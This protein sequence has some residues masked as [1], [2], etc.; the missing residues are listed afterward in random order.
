MRFSSDYTCLRIA[1]LTEDVI[2]KLVDKYNPGNYKEDA[3]IDGTRRLNEA[4]SQELPTK[5]DLVTEWIMSLDS[6]WAFAT[7]HDIE[8]FTSVVKFFFGHNKDPL[9]KALVKE[10]ADEIETQINPKNL[11]DFSWES[12]YV[13]R[14]RYS[15]AQATEELNLL[16]KKLPESAKLFYDDGA[17]KIVAAMRPEAA[18]ALGQG[19]EW[20]TREP[21]AA[22]DYLFRNKEI[23][24]LYVVYL[25]NR[26]VAQIHID[27]FKNTV[28]LKN[29]RNQNMTANSELT[30]V[31]WNS[32]LMKKVLDTFESLGT[33]ILYRSELLEKWVRFANKDILDYMSRLP[34]VAVAY[35]MKILKGPWPEAEPAIAKD[36]ETALKY[37]ERVLHKRF[38]EAEKT[39]LSGTEREMERYLN[40]LARV[41]PDGYKDL[42]QELLSQVKT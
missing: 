14:N 3:L 27:D 5:E 15:K 32:G 12:L 34:Y 25:N 40:T 16:P 24:P 42:T 28:E 41:D 1:V 37:V 10:Y 26:K 21:E 7:P 9:F 13:L 33:T 19:T 31:L 38:P 20:C 17:Y 35:A 8:S 11:F 23:F 6:N 39:I 18:C 30:T 22:E 29:I 36:P 4:V 2:K